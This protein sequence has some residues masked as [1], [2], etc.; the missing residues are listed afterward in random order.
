MFVLTGKGNGRVRRVRDRSRGVN[1]GVRSRWTGG[2]A[3]RSGGRSSGRTR[4]VEM[5]VFVLQGVEH[6]MCEWEEKPTW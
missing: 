5:E 4:E 1:D 2:P 6:D 3:L